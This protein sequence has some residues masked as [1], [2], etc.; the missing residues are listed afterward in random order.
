[1]NEIVC[2]HC[3]KP[4]Q[5]DEAVRH[6]MEKTILKEEREKSKAEVD[7]A[8]EEIAKELEE[9]LTAKAKKEMED[10]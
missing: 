9:R 8:R 4:I 10:A 1:M 7:K 2:P 5:I 3:G 6:Q